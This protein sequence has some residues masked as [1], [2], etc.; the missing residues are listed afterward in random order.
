MKKDW[1]QLIGTWQLTHISGQKVTVDPEHGPCI[2]TFNENFFVVQESS[3]HQ[4]RR[5][6]YVCYSDWNGLQTRNSVVLVHHLTKDRLLIEEL[7]WKNGEEVER[8]W[9]RFYKMRYR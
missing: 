6:P 4:K 1:K 5:I 2:Y 7:P 8:V 9:K 3:L